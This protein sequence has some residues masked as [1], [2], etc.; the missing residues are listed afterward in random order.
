MDYNAWIKVFT[1]Q[2]VHALY[3]ISLNYANPKSG[4]KKFA[5][6]LKSFDIEFLPFIE[7]INAKEEVIRECADAA[8]MERIRS[9]L[10]HMLLDTIGQN[11]TYAY[12]HRR[13]PSGYYIRAATFGQVEWLV[14][15][16]LH[17]IFQYGPI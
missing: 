5:S 4:I 1:H 10:L 8:T 14:H 3:N 12:R 9:M 17:F 11:L 2:L 6:T 15:T 16:S 7:E 13:Y